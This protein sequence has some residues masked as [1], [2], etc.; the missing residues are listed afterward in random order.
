MQ[1]TIYRT[2]VFRHIFATLSWLGLTLTGWKIVGEAPKEEKNVLIAAPHTSN[3]DFPVMVAM[4][5]ILRFEIYWMGK[6]TLF[7]GPAGP[8]MRWFGGIPIDRGKANNIVQS[9]IDAFNSHDRLI[10]IVPP[11]GTRFKVAGWKSGFYHIAHGAGVP[12][13]LGYLDFGGK[14]GGFGPTFHPTG[15]HDKDIA[16]IQSFYKDIKGKY[17]ENAAPIG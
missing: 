5:F 4:A 7:Q 16:E 13:G 8:V 17:P 1:N 3:W 15:D 10:V 12:I 2:P 14:R 9:T 6:D 11:E